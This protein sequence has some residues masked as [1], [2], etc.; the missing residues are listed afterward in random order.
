MLMS[1]FTKEGGS[2]AEGGGYT[3][4]IFLGLIAII[5]WMFFIRPQAKKAKTQKN[6]LAELQKGDKVITN[7]GIYGKVAKVDDTSVLLEVD[8]NT[9]I[10]MLKSSVSVEASESLNAPAEEEKK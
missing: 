9:K 8:T 7:G 1:P 5:F 4:F 10:R 2:S 6:F 3:Q